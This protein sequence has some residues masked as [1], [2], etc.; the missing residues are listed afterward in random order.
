MDDPTISRDDSRNF[1]SSLA[2][3]AA[4]S[5]S[6]AATTSE[7]GADQPRRRPDLAQGPL[8]TKARSEIAANPTMAAAPLRLWAARY[9][10]SSSARSAPPAQGGQALSPGR[11]GIRAP[12]RRTSRG[13]CRPWNRS[14]LQTPPVPADP[15]P[16]QHDTVG[17]TPVSGREI[18]LSTELYTKRTSQK[19]T[20]ERKPGTINHPGRFSAHAPART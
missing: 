10:R 19:V 1:A 6:L 16:M 13:T 8:H 4:S 3:R 15:R 14:T 7:L 12:P 17:S 11:P 9:T 18:E 2:I 20:L 5:S